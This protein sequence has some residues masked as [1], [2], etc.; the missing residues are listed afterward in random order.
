M[1]RITLSV[2]FI[3]L[4]LGLIC[5]AYALTAHDLWPTRLGNQWTYK[6]E[7]QIN[8]GD[9]FDVKVTQFFGG[10]AYLDATDEFF[11]TGW[12]DQ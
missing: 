8:N 10:W 12:G 4:S 7:G 9:E 2:L 3:I 1:R 11:G 6:I 5:N